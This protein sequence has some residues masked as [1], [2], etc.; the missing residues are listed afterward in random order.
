MHRV[1][2]LAA[3]KIVLRLGGALEGF[4][5]VRYVLQFDK[6]GAPRRYI[7]LLSIERP[8]DKGDTVTPFNRLDRYS[9]R[10]L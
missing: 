4:L 8:H 10:R 7:I 5:K 6:S 9:K 1:L 3:N 2:R